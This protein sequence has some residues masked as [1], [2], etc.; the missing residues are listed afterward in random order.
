MSE[1]STSS[2]VF[3]DEIWVDGQKRVHRIADMDI[4][5]ARNTHKYLTGHRVARMCLDS[6]SAAY[7]SGP[8]PSGDVAVDGYESG[9]RELEEAERNPVEWI[10]STPL[11]QA[12]A[13]RGWGNSTGEV[14]KPDS[15]EIPVVLKVRIKDGDNADVVEH[16]IRNALE[17]LPYDIE[18]M[19]LHP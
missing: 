8:M 6:I 12:L 19:D 16:D 4:H 7:L 11:A 2:L 3:Q 18:I 10:R 9:L 14:K 15:R 17:A 13:E 1:F 5:H